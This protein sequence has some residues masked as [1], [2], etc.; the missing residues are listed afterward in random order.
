MNIR[1]KFRLYFYLF[2][3]VKYLDHKC[4]DPEISTDITNL[5]CPAQLDVNREL[6]G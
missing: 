2:V 4:N 5:P 3:S 6:N 1:H